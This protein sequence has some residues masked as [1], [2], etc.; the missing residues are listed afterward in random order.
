MD[1]MTRQITGRQA[2]A[3]AQTVL[4]MPGPAETAIERLLDDE[5]TTTVAAQ[6]ATDQEDSQ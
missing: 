2:A 4:A 1:T 5:A 6:F 3:W